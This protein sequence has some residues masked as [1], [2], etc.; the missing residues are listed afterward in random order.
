[1]R[2]V[3]T[4]T[5]VERWRP[6]PEFEDHYQVSDRGRVRSLDRFDSIG[7]RIRGRILKPKLNRYGYPYVHLSRDGV[8]YARTV[9][10][11]V[12]RAFHGGP[13][14]Y[15]GVNGWRRHAEVR[16]RDGDRTNSRASNLCWSTAAQNQADRV[17]H[18]T[19][20]RGERS[21]SRTKPHRLPRGERHGMAKLTEDQVRAIR[22]DSRPQRLIA[23]EYGIRQPA[24]SR[25]KRGHR[26]AHTA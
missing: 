5:P 8:A 4:R 3:R 11:L 1:M 17:R 9:H 24:V 13:F 16:H 15:R 22:L 12:A 2:E 25:I 19:D 21:P 14:R 6:C 7:R 20:C 10:R 23:A 26:W 18:G